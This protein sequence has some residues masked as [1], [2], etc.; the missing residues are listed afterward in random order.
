MDQLDDVVLAEARSLVRADREMPDDAAG[1]HEACLADGYACG[2]DRVRAD[3]LDHAALRVVHEGAGE[4]DL[5]ALPPKGAA[6]AVA[7]RRVLKREGQQ[8]QL[9][10]AGVLTIMIRRVGEPRAARFLVLQ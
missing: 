9:H 4:V 2:Y 8:V 1:L 5:D 3:Q 7:D 10:R 6:L